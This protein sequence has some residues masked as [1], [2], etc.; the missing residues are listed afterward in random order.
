MSR[1]QLAELTVAVLRYAVG[2]IA[3]G[4]EAALLELGLESEQ[5]REIAALTLE[6]IENLDAVRVSCVEVRIQPEGFQI[7]MNRL[8]RARRNKGLEL[9]LIQA[10]A[11]EL[12]MRTLFGMKQRDYSRTRRLLGVETGVGRPPSLDEE[13]EHALWRAVADSLS[14]NPRRPLEP[15]LYLQTHRELGVPMRALWGCTQRWARE[16]NAEA[17][18]GRQAASLRPMFQAGTIPRRGDGCATN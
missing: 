4:D 12:M 3:H 1:N 13:T 7:L 2:C 17:K 5:L 10:D 11:P 16:R 8:A 9:A 15:D 18:S 6:D 14:G